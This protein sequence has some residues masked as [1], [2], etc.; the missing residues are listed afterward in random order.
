MILFGSL[1]SGR[2]NHPI[3]LP[4]RFLKDYAKLSIKEIVRFHGVPCQPF[5]IE[6]LNLVHTF[7]SIPNTTS[8]KCET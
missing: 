1:L 4:S 8:Y 3:S 5:Q 6:V 7:E 2:P